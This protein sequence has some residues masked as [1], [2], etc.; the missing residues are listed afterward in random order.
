M[1]HA[2]AAI[3]GTTLLSIAFMLGAALIFVTVFRKLG[4]GAT[5]GYIVGGAVIGHGLGL[6]LCPDPLVVGLDLAPDLVVVPAQLLRH[7][8]GGRLGSGD[9]AVPDLDGDAGTARQHV[10]EVTPP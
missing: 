3:S 9:P 8:P 2:Q 5:L 4:L 10:V 6:A 7:E 1:N